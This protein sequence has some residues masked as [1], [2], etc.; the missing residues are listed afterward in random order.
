VLFDIDGTL[1]RRSGPA[2]REALQYAARQVFQVPATIDGIPVHGQLDTGILQVMLRR[3][4]VPVREIRAAMPELIRLTEE[5][6][7]IHAPASLKANLCPGVEN[8]LEG[9]RQREVPLVLVTGN[10]PSIGWRKL[11]L[12]GIRDYFL[13]GAFAGMRSTRT[14]LARYAIRRAKQQGWATMDASIALIGDSPNDIAAA[15]ANGI[16]SVAVATGIDTLD[17][18]RGHAPGV[19]VET[20]YHLALDNLLCVEQPA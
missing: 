15:R 2:H 5:R 1:I 17:E 20:L 10:F 4:G 7:A 6:Y 19:L 9:L 16:R 18:L 13:D 11:E 8:L 12:A 3:E 14:A